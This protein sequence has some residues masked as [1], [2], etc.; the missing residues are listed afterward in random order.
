[1]NVSER[2]GFI[3]APNP[4]PM[5]LDGTNTWILRAPG[6][7][8]SVVVDP[9]PLDEG[10]LQAVKEEAGD[11]ALIL[12]THHHGDHTDGLSRF[13]ELSGAP[14]R[15]L[16]PEYTIAADPLADAEIIDVDG[17]RIEVLAT[18]GHTADSICFILPQDR[19]LVTGDTVLGRGTT[20]IVH[21]DGALGPYLDSIRN[22]RTVVDDHGLERILPAHGPI[23]D[24][25]AA[26]LDYYIAHREERLEQVRAAVTTGAR[27][28]AEVVEIVYADVDRSL[29][30]AAER[31]VEAQLEYLGV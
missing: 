25:P 31:S 4:G 11:V 8:Q 28:A 6:A 7:S 5:T 24:Q 22:M 13:H 15:A 14:S 30:T 26:V 3:L 9:G 20:I 12:V 16:L 17:L 27:T 10:H 21:P 19:S 18:P 23:I 29:W 1:M 2:A